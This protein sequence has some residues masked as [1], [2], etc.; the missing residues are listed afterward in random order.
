MLIFLAVLLVLSSF[1]SL[2]LFNLYA[3]ERG[4]HFSGE[5]LFSRARVRE[6]AVGGRREGEGSMHNKMRGKEGVPE[7]GG[8]DRE[9]EITRK[10]ERR[11]R[12]RG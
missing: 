1:S 11:E 10:R 7:R 9:C 3:L 2:F 5:R 8:R 12:E 6:E 4:K